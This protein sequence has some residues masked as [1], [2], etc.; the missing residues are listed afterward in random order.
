MGIL[1]KVLGPKSKYDS[2]LPY[3]YEARVKIFEEG[4]EFNSCFADTI[5][6]LVDYLGANKRSSGEVE[7]FEIYQNKE[8]PIDTRILTAPDGAW[9]SKRE[10]CRAFEAH[11]PGHIQAESCSFEDRDGGCAGP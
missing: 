3:T 6:G 7:I 8:F 11:Y 9:L 4:E 5:C 1:E 2:S 10:L